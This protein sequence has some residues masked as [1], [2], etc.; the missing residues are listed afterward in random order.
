MLHVKR[1]AKFLY[2]LVCFHLQK[3]IMGFDKE[4]YHMVSEALQ[5]RAN[6]VDIAPHLAYALPIMLP[7]YTYYPAIFNRENYTS[8]FFLMTKEMI[9]R[10]NRFCSAFTVAFFK[11]EKN[12]LAQHEF[13]PFS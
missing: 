4:Q 8:C 2:F 7:V 3:A 12:P 5:E 6:L 13:F 1:L 11:S 9:S 10:T